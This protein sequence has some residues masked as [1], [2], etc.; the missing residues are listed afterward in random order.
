GEQT[1]P[2]QP[3]PSKPPAFDRQGVSI[4]DLIDFTP[5]LRAAALD[6]AKR[7]VIGPVF[8]PPSIKGTGPTDTRG[9]IQL[10]GSVGGADWQGAALDPD[11]GISDLQSTPGP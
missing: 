3:F 8:T 7:Y 4:D 1:S 9:T 6:I 2:T 10:P 11:G 5:E